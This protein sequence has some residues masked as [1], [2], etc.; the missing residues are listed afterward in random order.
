M[1]PLQLSPIT[2]LLA[3]LFQRLCEMFSSAER[4]SLCGEVLRDLEERLH[5]LLRW[6]GDCVIGS[7]LSWL[8]RQTDFESRVID[9][10]RSSSEQGWRSKGKREVV[11]RLLGGHLVRLPV[12][13]GHEVRRK[14]GRKRGRGKRRKGQGHHNTPILQALGFVGHSSAA[15]GSLIVTQCAAQES[16]DAACM[17]LESR[18]IELSKQQLQRHF[19][20]I[21]RLLRSAQEQW[22]Q[23]DELLEGERSCASRRIV[24]VFDGGR[25]R[26]RIDK[27]GRK[28]S[29]GYRNFDAP[30]VEPRCAVIYAI[31]DQGRLDKSFGKWGISALEDHEQLFGRLVKL[32]RKLKISHANEVI[33][34]AD[35]QRWQ[36]PK[37]RQCLLDAG[38]Y[39]GV[40][41]EVLD[42]SHAVGRLHEIA[43]VPRWSA[44][45][46]ES[47]LSKAKELLRQG[48]VEELAPHCDILAKTRRAKK[49]NSLTEYFVHHV[50]RMRYD[51]FE[52]RKIPK[53]SGVVESFIRQVVNM[54]LKACGKFWKREHAQL[55]LLARNYLKIGRLDSLFS[56]TLRQQAH[57][58]RPSMGK[59]S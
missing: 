39:R 58:W 8:L 14:R 24:L 2:D 17:S 25:L 5:G 10:K 19:Y 27:P 59:H 45:Q 7:F 31:D 4:R 35:G 53:G 12:Q 44:Q 28:K 55:M 51:I 48:R 49:I 52:K 30:W 21:T 41:Y 9:A 6:F 23:G 11:V 34:C 26:E 1:P 15:L 32:L 38:V 20:A 22:L 13:H 54:R 47:W 57:F 33:I 16:F 40:I 37:L 42:K 3:T 29:N 18:G 50:E 46:R 43:Q 56:F 36:W